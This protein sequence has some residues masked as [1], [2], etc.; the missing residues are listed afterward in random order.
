MRFVLVPWLALAS[1]TAACN[2]HND[3]PVSP[4]NV[5]LEITTLYPRNN[6]AWLA[7]RKPDPV[8]A[9]DQGYPG[10][11]GPVT[12]GCDTPSPTAAPPDDCTPRRLLGVQTDVENFYLRPPDAC[13]GTAQC[14]FLIVELDPGP[15]GPAVSARAATTSVVLDL[16]ALDAAG[17]LV[18]PHVLRP[19]LV[20]PDLT[21]FTTPY[22]FE[23]ED[24]SVTFA[25][26]AC[27][28]T[29]ANGGDCGGGTAGAPNE[30]GGAPNDGAG[31]SDH[32]GAGGVANQ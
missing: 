17:T 23:P 16:S 15:A 22:A 30:A 26:D 10:D 12:L 32:A 8:L 7:P 6:D 20:L 29:S 19:R 28:P 31:A 18:G 1:A 14:G 13:S 21:P 27:S 2:T 3:T 11:P 24:V 5:V 25:A 9:G 4:G